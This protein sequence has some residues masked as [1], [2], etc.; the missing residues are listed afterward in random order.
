MPLKLNMGVEKRG[1][2]VLM[3]LPVPLCGQCEKKER[4]ITYLTLVPFAT[5]GLIV[6]V[7]VFIP[8]ML[9]TPAGTTSQ[10]LDAPFVVGALAGI[11]AG[12]IGGTLAEVT[13]RLVFA[14]VY[15]RL[16]LKRPLMILSL[17]D[18][19]ED[20]L[21][22]SARFGKNRESLG[23]TFENESIAQDFIRLNSL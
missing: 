22:L 13:I 2:G 19:S 23:L 8:V 7:F 3:N 1:Q 15:G 16:L 4:K 14:P 20:V 21:G 18:D 10:T 5:V 6:F 17:F 9:V 11:I 12:L